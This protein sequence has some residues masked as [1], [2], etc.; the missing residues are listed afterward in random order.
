MKFQGTLGEFFNNNVVW[1]SS[2]SS[3]HALIFPCHKLKSNVIQQKTQV[4]ECSDLSLSHQIIFPIVTENGRGQ[5]WCCWH[6]PLQFSCVFCCDWNC[7]C[8]MA[9][10]PTSH[11]SGQ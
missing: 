11:P 3:L 6:Q 9:S 4:D 8:A 1:S 5:W 7:L 10:T 2:A